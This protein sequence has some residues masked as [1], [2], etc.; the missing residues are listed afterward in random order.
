MGKDSVYSV[1]WSDVVL[2]VLL[3]ILYICAGALL[4]LALYFYVVE[5][6][7]SNL[8]NLEQAVFVFGTI[9]I[10]IL[11]SLAIIGTGKGFELWD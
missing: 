8:I 2:S 5:V 3:F 6:G 1:I 4:T 11:V 9:F 7:W 10:W